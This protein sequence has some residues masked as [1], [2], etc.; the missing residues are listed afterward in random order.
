MSASRSSCSLHLADS[1]DSKP[2]LLPLVG[3]EFRPAGFRERPPRRT[4]HHVAPPVPPE[5]TTTRLTVESP[6]NNILYWKHPNNAVTRTGGKSEEFVGE[7]EI[8]CD[9]GLILVNTHSG[10]PLLT[11]TRRDA[12]GDE[13]VQK[14]PRRYAHSAH[15]PPHL[16]PTGSSD[17]LTMDSNQKRLEDILLDKLE[18]LF[19]SRKV[20]NESVRNDFNK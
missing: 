12:N 2:K 1:S 16:T 7:F 11:S 3:H 13:R 5:S 14:E 20:F 18:S 8:G 17:Q 6:C 4:R 19:V 9:G 10:L 15:T